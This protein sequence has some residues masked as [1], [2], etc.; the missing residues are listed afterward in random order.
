MDFTPHNS[1]HAVQRTVFA[2]FFPDTPLARPLAKSDFTKD[3]K[4]LATLPG[5]RPFQAI[6]IAIDEGVA[7]QGPTD[8]GLQ[9]FLSE[10]DG[11]HAWLLQVAANHILVECRI[12]TR[13]AYVWQMAQT[14][15]SE[16]LAAVVGVLEKPV[17]VTRLEL[18]VTDRFET[19]LPTYR[20][21]TLLKPNS[22]IPLKMFESGPAWH[23]HLGWYD[24][25]KPRVLN[26]VNF[27]AKP[28]VDKQDDG[29]WQIEILHFQRMQ[30]ERAYEGRSASELEPS[31]LRM[32]NQ[33]TAIVR[34]VLTEKMAR[35]I[36]V[37]RDT[38]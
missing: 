25:V 9:L 5:S 14:Y 17:S 4:A 24:E 11:S 10:P 21:N 6:N 12:Y 37:L 28:V 23:T 15:L 35:Q 36:G 31:F 29:P 8:T 34:D 18:V 32:H 19:P 1:K 2:V 16:A 7:R 22:F 20:L 33:N 30:L 27:D 13:W 3:A 38:K 26:N